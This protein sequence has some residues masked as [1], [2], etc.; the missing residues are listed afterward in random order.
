MMKAPV[1]L[2]TEY[3]RTES[4]AAIELICPVDSP[5]AVRAAVDHGADWVHLSCFRYGGKCLGKP[6]FEDIAL[7]KGVRYAHDRHCRISLALPNEAGSAWQASTQAV[8]CAALAGVDALM[9]SDPALMLYAAAHHPDVH[10]HYV[11]PEA[12]L[13]HGCAAFLQRQLGA[14]RIV[15]PRVLPLPMLDRLSRCP[16]PEFVVR[17]SARLL[18]PAHRHARLPAAAAGQPAR[19]AAASAGLYGDGGS[20]ANDG[21]YGPERG[22]DCDALRFLPQLATLGIRAILV[23]APGRA[24]ARLAQVTCIWRE[25]IDDCLADM[26]HYTVRSVWLEGLARAAKISG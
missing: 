2:F 19:V 25:A 14:R 7:R 5:A 26:G 18:G 1:N 4:H 20:A 16:G 22:A 12:M 15:L 9:L 3:T 10:L 8:D 17:G 21:R 24:P 13:D 11:M 23:Q 6:D